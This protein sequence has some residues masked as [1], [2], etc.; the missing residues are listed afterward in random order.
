MSGSRS[1]DFLSMAAS[2]LRSVTCGRGL[3][4]LACDERDRGKGDLD[5]ATLPKASRCSWSGPPQWDG[6]CCPYS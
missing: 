3:S 1:C 4:K 6:P 5:L 2:L